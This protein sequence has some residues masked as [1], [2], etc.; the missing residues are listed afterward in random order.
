M[1][2]H[3]KSLENQEE[4]QV[5]KAAALMRRYFLK[6]HKQT[7]EHAFTV[8]KACFTKWQ[9][10][11]PYQSLSTAEQFS[12]KDTNDELERLEHTNDVLRSKFDRVQSQI[13]K[14][15]DK[16]DIFNKESKDKIEAQ[17]EF[18][19]KEMQRI[20]LKRMCSL[21]TEQYFRSTFH[22]IEGVADFKTNKAALLNKMPLPRRKK[23][24]EKLAER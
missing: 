13:Q 4:V 5:S 6:M 1:I 21:M 7:T 20:K 11:N 14:Q 17:Q 3:P 9:E 8:W 2:D 18:C 12:V 22:M 19:D 24:W 10:A 23:W 16:L 15:K